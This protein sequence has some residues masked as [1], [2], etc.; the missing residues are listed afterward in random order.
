[1]I[2]Y[3]D[4][5]LIDAW[6]ETYKI[7]PIIR[8]NSGFARALQF[9]EQEHFGV[10]ESTMDVYWM[11]ESYLYY[12]EYVDVMYRISTIPKLPF[13]VESIGKEEVVHDHHSLSNLKSME[14]EAIQT[15]LELKEE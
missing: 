11:S 12:I 10:T 7:R 3:L 14:Q 1:M 5:K 15:M 4:M 2:K 9:Y 13:P 8:P 6:N